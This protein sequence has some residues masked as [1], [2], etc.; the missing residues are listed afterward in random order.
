[1][2]AAFG[3]FILD[4]DR[5]ELTRRG[6]AVRLAP[7]AFQ[8]LQILFE[9]RPKAVSQQQLYDQLWPDT[10]VEKSNL[11][12][13]I[14]QVREALHDDDQTIIRT[15]Y[16]FGFAFA[17]ADAGVR[18][19]LVVGGRDIDLHDGENI[20]GRDAGASVQIEAR[21]I[22]RRHA[23]LVVS[24]SGVTLEDLGSK[25]GT[26]VGDRRI[27]SVTELRDGDRIVFGSV[28]ATLRAVRPATSTET[29]T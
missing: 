25:N 24:S 9:A 8:L 19:Q 22:S 20:V 26:T 21:S 15:V 29:V 17:G 23:R 11:H 7:K 16:A 2:R 5:R 1:M 13:L 6:K 3:D 4:I 14:Y 12:N 28:P 10:F 18:W 27:D